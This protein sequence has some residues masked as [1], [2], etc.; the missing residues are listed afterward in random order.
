MA[1]LSL[2]LASAMLPALLAAPGAV[3][4]GGPVESALDLPPVYTRPWQQVAPDATWVERIERLFVT[5]VITDEGKR[6]R[7]VRKWDGPIAIAVRGDAAPA[8]VGFVEDTARDL[9]S[10]AGLDIHVELSPSR[11]SPIELMVTWNPSYWPAGISA[12][13]GPRMPF[14]C[15]ALPSSRNGSFRASRVL[16]N[17][18]VVGEDGARACILEE[19]SQSLGLLGEV[20]EPASLLTDRIGYQQLGAV[21]AL[22]LRVLYDP[23]L[24]A[25]L[26][27]DEAIIR[28]RAIVAEKLGLRD[29]AEETPLP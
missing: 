8:F 15:M 27:H 3:R 5:G 7:E 11:Q 14:T 28:V 20:D 25:G 10:A 1:C 23:R 17:A 6:F 21:D 22:L 4:A 16:V 9:G 2:L 29:G 26:S 12:R 24:P 13:G 19:L 18:G